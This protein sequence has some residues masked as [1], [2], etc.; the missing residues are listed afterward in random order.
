LLSDLLCGQH[1]RA[2]PL[3]E[4]DSVLIGIQ[5]GE[6]NKWIQNNY[7]QNKKAG[8]NK[9]RIHTTKYCIIK[10]QNVARENGGGA[11]SFSQQ[12]VIF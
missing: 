4:T 8:D 1:F 6:P 9:I 11:L 12:N 7:Y 3:N 5:T 2:K 10:K